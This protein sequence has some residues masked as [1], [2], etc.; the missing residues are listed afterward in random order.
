MP[1]STAEQ[2]RKV[3]ATLDAAITAYRNAE[4]AGV[5][6]PKAS[7]YVKAECE[8]PRT[9]RVGKTVLAQA[10][11]IC[12]ECGKDFCSPEAGDEDQD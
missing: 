9:I 10:P 11:I 7:N 1:P 3:I 2:Y 8:C 6:R 4:V 5:S 12:D